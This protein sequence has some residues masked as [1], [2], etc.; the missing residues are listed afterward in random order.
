MSPSQPAAGPGLQ[1]TRRRASRDANGDDPRQA[2]ELRRAVASLVVRGR[3]APSLATR[4]VGGSSATAGGGTWHAT[5]E[6]WGRL[7]FQDT[8]GR[9]PALAPAATRAGPL[10]PAGGRGY[11]RRSQD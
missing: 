1:P 6:G 5:F 4:N 9:K 8:I 2:R 10:A 11:S 3:A 7:P